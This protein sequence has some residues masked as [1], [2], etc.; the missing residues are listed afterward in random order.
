LRGRNDCGNLIKRN[1]TLI[2]DSDAKSKSMIKI[3]CITVLIWCSHSGFTQQREFFET[4]YP[5]LKLKP[6]K[7]KYKVAATDYLNSIRI[8]RG[9]QPV[10]LNRWLTIKCNLFSVWHKLFFQEFTHA[11][12]RPNSWENLTTDTKWYID[13]WLGSTSHRKNMLIRSTYKIGLG[14]AGGVAVQRGRFR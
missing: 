12:I 10:K 11:Y 6:N 8:E 7:W 3:L 14:T 1:A 13:S 9:L 5:K 2:R 4:N